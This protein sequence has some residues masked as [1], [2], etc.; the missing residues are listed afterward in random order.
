[1]ENSQKSNYLDN[2]FHYNFL[3]LVVKSIFYWL[4]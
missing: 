3:S 2:F 1:M 4:V